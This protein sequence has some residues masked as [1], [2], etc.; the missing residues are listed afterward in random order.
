MDFSTPQQ[1][2]RHHKGQ[3]LLTCTHQHHCVKPHRQ[4]KEAS[5][6][7]HFRVVRGHSVTDKP[8]GN[9]QLL[10]DVHLGPAMVLQKEV[11]IKAQGQKGHRSSAAQV[12]HTMLAY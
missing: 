11:T 2:L 10:I 7:L 1:V 9:R 3:K 5:T 4:G 12:G 6:N 8:K